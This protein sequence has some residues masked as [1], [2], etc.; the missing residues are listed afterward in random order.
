[1]AS[2]WGEGAV[3]RGGFLGELRGRVE[4]ASVWWVCLNLVVVGCRICCVDEYSVGRLG[5][6]SSQGLLDLAQ[7]LVLEQKT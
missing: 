7:Y 2:G 3:G 4:G 6:V 1:M 5:L